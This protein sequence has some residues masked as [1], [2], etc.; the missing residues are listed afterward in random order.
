MDAQV[1]EPLGARVTGLSLTAPPDD[2]TAGTL[3]GLLA[4]HGVVHVPA[5]DIDDTAFAAFLRCFGDPVFTVG[6]TPVPGF[7]DLNVISNVGRTTPPRSTFHVDTSYVSSPPAYT[8]LRAVTI[9]EQGGQTVFSIEGRRMRHVV[10]GVDPGEDQEKQAWHPLVR[11]HPVSGRDTLYLTTPARCAEIEGMDADETAATVAA[12][13]AHSTAPE[14]CLR[15][16]WAP[17]DVVMWD[18]GTVLHAADHS[19]VVGDRVMHRGMA[20]GYGDPVSGTLSE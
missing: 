15:H 5:Q 12:L 16:T 19:G 18:N 4:D 1:L 13:H 8:A 7:D 17:G 9:P 2:A 3:V 11:P 6:E 20:T 10:T 14:N